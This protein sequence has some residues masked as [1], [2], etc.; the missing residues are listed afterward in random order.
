MQM[1]GR[2]WGTGVP[3]R[4]NLCVLTNFIS[5]F[6]SHCFKVRIEGIVYFAVKIVFDYHRVSVTIILLRSMVSRI[7]YLST[8]YSRNTLTFV[9]R[10]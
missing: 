7:N 10:A 3:D 2:I 9:I 6:H 5:F 4:A 1:I 8:I